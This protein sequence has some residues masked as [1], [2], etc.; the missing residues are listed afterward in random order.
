MGLTCKPNIYLFGSTSELRLR[1]VPFNMYK[2]S[3]NFFIDHSKTYEAFQYWGG[4]SQRGQL[5]Y[6]GF[7]QNVHS[8]MHSRTRMYSHMYML[9]NVHTPMHAYT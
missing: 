8:R 4:Q 6:L 9:P 1:M 3:S 2:P 7:L 5:Q